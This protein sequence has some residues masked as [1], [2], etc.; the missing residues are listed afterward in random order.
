MNNIISVLL[1]DSSET[2]KWLINAGLVKGARKAFGKGIFPCEGRYITNRGAFEEETT[3]GVFRLP[4][5]ADI[6]HSFVIKF[7]RR[8]ECTT[9]NFCKTIRIRCGGRPMFEISRAKNET[10]ARA[11]GRW[12]D[13]NNDSLRECPGSA[14]AVP[15]MDGTNYFQCMLVWHELAIE[16]EGIHM[17]CRPVLHAECVHLDEEILKVIK[18]KAAA[19]IPQPVAPIAGTVDVLNRTYEWT[20]PKACENCSSIEIDLAETKF[21]G[22]HVLVYL[23]TDQPRPAASHPI[24]SIDL[25]FEDRVAMTYDHLDL[26]E[27]NWTKCGL[28]SPFGAIRSPEACISEFAYLVPFSREAFRDPPTSCLDATRTFKASLVARKEGGD[29]PKGR[30]QVAQ[31]CLNARRV[32]HGMCGLT[33]CYA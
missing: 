17:D 13:F 24:T 8:G 18:E 28:L 19:K 27:L 15:I 11:R 20:R 33:H 23:L 14:F 1:F 2:L 3:R 25:K 12:P 7:E 30:L 31:D 22:T 5:C 10:V 21:I 29:I 4:K 6:L 32:R 9:D 16:L 26:E